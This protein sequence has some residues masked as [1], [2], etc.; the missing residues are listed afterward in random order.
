MHSDEKKRAPGTGGEERHDDELLRGKE[1]VVRFF[2]DN[3]TPLN[4][5]KSK[6]P[7]RLQDEGDIYFLTVEAY[8]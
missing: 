8:R 2:K 7:F 5:N 4:V 3:G 1:E 6:I